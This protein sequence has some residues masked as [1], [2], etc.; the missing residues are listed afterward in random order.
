MPVMLDKQFDIYNLVSTN[1]YTQVQH[2]TVCAIKAESEKKLDIDDRD[3]RIKSEGSMMLLILKA[4][5]IRK[6]DPNNSYQM[7]ARF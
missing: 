5:W 3:P 1:T 6:F 4:I 7:I 2:I